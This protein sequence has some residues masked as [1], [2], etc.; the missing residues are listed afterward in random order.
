M[1]FLRACFLYCLALISRSKLRVNSIQS[2]RN[3]WTP[4]SFLFS[5]TISQTSK[6]RWGE[7]QRTKHLTLTKFQKILVESDSGHCGRFLNWTQPNLVKKSLLL[8]K[9]SR[10]KTL[11]KWI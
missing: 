4:R 11:Q 10:E 7:R 5:T 8:T 3:W 9:D 2:G 6:K 1:N